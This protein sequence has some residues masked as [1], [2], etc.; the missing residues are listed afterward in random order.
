MPDEAR[1][2]HPRHA[3]TFPEFGAA[4]AGALPGRPALADG[5]AEGPVAALAAPAA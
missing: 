3:D 2:P 1:P 4:E 5:E